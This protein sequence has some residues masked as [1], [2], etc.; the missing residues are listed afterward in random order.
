[1]SVLSKLAG[2]LQTAFQIGKTG[3]KIK[4]NAGV[5]EARNAADSAYV[6]VKAA[7]VQGTTALLNGNILLEEDAGQLS[8]RN[9][10]DS[11]YLKILALTPTTGDTNALATVGYINANPPTTAA[12]VRFFSINTP[13]TGAPNFPG[14][15]TIPDQA[16]ITRCVVETVVALQ[17]GSSAAVNVKVGTDEAGQDARFQAYTDNDTQVQDTYETTPFKSMKSSGSGTTQKFL[18]TTSAT[19]ATGQVNIYIEYLVPN[20][21]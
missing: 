19:P 11:A 8:V 20:V 10:G 1:M 17:D 12:Q 7:Q 13:Y 5:I 6:N 18:I 9:S 2:T 4:N 15:V 16:I 14:S 3:P 21:I